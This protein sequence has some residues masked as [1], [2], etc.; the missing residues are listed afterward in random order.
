M[1]GIGHDH[2]GLQA[3]QGAVGAPLLGELD[4]GPRQGAPEGLELAL[5][6]FQKREPVGRRSSEARQHRAV[7]QPPHLAGSVLDHRGPQRDLPVAAHRQSP[8]PAHSQDGGTV[9]P[10]ESSALRRIRKAPIHGPPTYPE[11]PAASTRG[12]VLFDNRAPPRS[13]LSRGL[14]IHSPAL[15]PSRPLPPTASARVR[16]LGD[17]DRLGK[18]VVSVALPQSP[19]SKRDVNTI[20]NH[21]VGSPEACGRSSK[22]ARDSPIIKV[23]AA[24][25]RSV[26]P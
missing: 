6:T 9:R 23:E 16:F 21:R 14:L 1:L 26:Q 13:P 7:R 5:E 19:Q 24:G 17:S 11:R 8:V 25:T 10:H 3:A 22:S 4:G 18:Q 12:G 2:G 20:L 15:L